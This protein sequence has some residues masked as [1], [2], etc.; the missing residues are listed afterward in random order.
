MGTRQPTKG[1]T[2]H[3]ATRMPE[4]EKQ[5]AV[6]SEGSGESLEKPGGLSFEVVLEEAK[7]K[8]APKL[9]CPSTP[10]PSV[11]DIE[12]RLKE[13]ENRRKSM[14]ASTLEKLAQEEKK[15]R[16]GPRGEGGRKR[17]G[18]LKSFEASKT[19]CFFLFAVFKLQ[20]NHQQPYPPLNHFVHQGCDLDVYYTLEPPK[21]AVGR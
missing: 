16:G 2:H 9:E 18:C 7:I 11:E 17:G 19:F 8:E 3:P 14:E 21:L 5:S 20:L 12:K 6:A 15:E 1:R 10:A 4:V 13:A